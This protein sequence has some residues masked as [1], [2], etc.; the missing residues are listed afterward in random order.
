M[1]E[2][3]GKVWRALSNVSYGGNRVFSRL[4]SWL[5]AGHHRDSRTNKPAKRDNRV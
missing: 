3:L 2:D 5:A 1:T 4:V